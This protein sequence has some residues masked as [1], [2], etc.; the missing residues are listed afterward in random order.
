[1]AAIT[2]ALIQALNTG[3][4]ADFQNAFNAMHGQ[5]HY[6]RVA[7][8]VP[9]STASNTY[10]WLGNM[11]M[12]R[13]WV[14]DRSVKDIKQHGYQILNKGFESTVS[15]KRTDIEDDQVGIYR[16]LME[17]L[18]K[19]AAQFMDQQI[20]GLLKNGDTQLCYDG[21]FFFDVDHPV[22]P[23]TDGT[24][25]ASMASNFTA[26]AA[27][28]WYLLDITNIMKPFIWQSRKTA[29][30]TT[31]TD[32]QDERVFMSNEYRYGVDLR[33]N[34]GYAFWQLAH[35]SKAA[36][37]A[38]SYAAARAAMMSLKSDGNR[39]L[40]IS[41]SLLVVPPSLEGA[42]RRLLKKDLDGGNEWY[43][44]ADVLVTPYVI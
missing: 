42:A 38:N 35:K 24:G 16:P 1:M 5:T 4:R 12:L 7:T 30:F 25:T 29:Q 32:N 20:F 40:N 22:Y 41:P 26:G 37:D 8:V 2:A 14:G 36:L 11:P 39:E 44:T 19:A 6:E 27:P 34:A 33:G 10:G 18:G 43:G 9:S 15:V 17:G 13:E 28:A 3:F 31:M 21:Q 23:N